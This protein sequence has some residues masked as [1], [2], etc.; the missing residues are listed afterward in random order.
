MTK[1]FGSSLERLLRLSTE[2]RPCAWSI[3]NPSTISSNFKSGSCTLD[4]RSRHFLSDSERKVLDEMLILGSRFS[5]NSTVSDRP[6]F[7]DCWCFVRRWA[8]DSRL[9]SCEEIPDLEPTLLDPLVM[10]PDLDLDPEA[11][12]V[13]EWWM[14]GPDSE[15]LFWA[16]SISWSSLARSNKGTSVVLEL[17][18][19]CECTL[20]FVSLREEDSRL[21][22]RVGSCI[23]IALD[24]LKGF[25]ILMSSETLLVPILVSYVD[26]D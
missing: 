7:D 9:S 16:A 10:E 5:T 11:E 21:V 6:G 19:T 14:V 23:P 25:A 20:K 24:P 4:D 17:Q 8:F 26:R 15:I 22:E 3:F 13:A 1:W 2:S 18:L 12:R